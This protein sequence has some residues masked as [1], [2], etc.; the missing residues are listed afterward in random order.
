MNAYTEAKMEGNL[1]IHVLPNGLLVSISIQQNHNLVFV[2]QHL[3]S[4]SEFMED[5]EP[6]VQISNDSNLRHFIDLVPNNNG[7]FSVQTVHTE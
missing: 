6:N 4:I 3:S 2:E 1:G 7:H 5:L